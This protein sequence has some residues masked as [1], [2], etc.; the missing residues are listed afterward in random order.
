MMEGILS[1]TKKLLCMKKSFLIVIAVTITILSFAQEQEV[2]APF[3][4]QVSGLVYVYNY[5]ISTR[6]QQ[7]TF[8]IPKPPLKFEI[9]RKEQNTST[10]NANY[11]YYIIKFL[12]ITSD[13]VTVAGATVS[14][15]NSTQ[16]VNSADNQGYFWIRQDE[17]NN[18]LDDKTIKKSYKFTHNLAYGANV[19][20]PFK[21]RPKVNDQNIRITPDITLTGY[22]GVKHRISHK[23]PFYITFPMVTLGLATLPITGETDGSVDDKGDGMVLGVTTSTGLVFQ[24]KD[25]QLGFLM[26]WDKAAG[27]LG[28]TW[29]Y[30]GKTWYSFSIGFTFLGNNK[31]PEEKK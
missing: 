23:D 15:T 10:A 24:L 1:Q 3:Y 4:Y 9:V 19:S 25:F 31:Q 2:D 13:N 29:I 8:K 6:T 7:T 27:E 26:G 28:K 21:L 17:L 16:F 14:L 22:L 11:D 5:N 18:L 20:L 12:P 30:N